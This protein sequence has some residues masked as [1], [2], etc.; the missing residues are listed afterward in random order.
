MAE[1]KE[2]TIGQWLE[3]LTNSDTSS[4]RDSTKMQNLL[5]MVGYPKAMVALG[6][7]YLT[8]YGY[9]CSIHAMARQ[10]VD[11]VEEARFKV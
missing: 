9:P 1:Q 11:K 2:Q 3:G 8:G 7:V 6:I 10:M 4:D 5:R